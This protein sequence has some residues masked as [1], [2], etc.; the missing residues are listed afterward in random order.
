MLDPKLINL[1][2]QFPEFD[3][4]LLLIYT[5]LKD[6][7]IQAK[8]SDCIF[9]ICRTIDFECLEQAGFKLNTI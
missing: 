9:T 3:N 7:L 6:Q 5:Q 8:V 4:T 1:M 2:Y